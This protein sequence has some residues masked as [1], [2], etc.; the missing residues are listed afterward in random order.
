MAYKKK[1]TRGRKK[2]KKANVGFL[3]IDGLCWS[4]AIWRKSKDKKASRCR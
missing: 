4:S 3:K 2:I 1:K